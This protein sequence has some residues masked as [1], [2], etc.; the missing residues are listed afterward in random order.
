MSDNAESPYEVGGTERTL[1][2]S[3]RRITIDDGT[4]IVHESLG[5]TLVSAWA[6]DLGEQYV[7]VVHLGHGPSGGELVLVLPDRNVVVIGD[8]YAASPAGAT[9]TWAE[10]VDLT[11]GLTTL[12]TKI[13]SSSGPVTRD[14]LEAFHQQL[15]GV[16]HG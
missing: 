2:Y 4:E 10:A 5:G 7:E 11:L 12:S 13:L 8:L 16:L 6:G 1:T 9:P 15:L 14:E 3:P